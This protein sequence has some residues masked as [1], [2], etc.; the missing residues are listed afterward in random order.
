M[1][2]RPRTTLTTPSVSVVVPCYNY[3]RFLQ[4][5]VRSALD[6]EGVTVEVIIVDD[7]SP[8]GSVVVAH[9]LAAQDDRVRVIAHEENRGH[10]A[11]YNDGLAAVAAKYVVLLSADDLLAPGSLAR[12]TAL[13]ERHP[14]V[15]LVYGYAPTFT[16]DRPQ[17]R[18]APVWG[19]SIWSGERWLRRTCRTGHNRIV[20]PEAVMRTSV[21]A[22]IGAYDPHLPHSADLDLWMRAALVADVGRVNG[23]AQAYY[24]SHGANMHLTDYSGVLTDMKQRA[25]GFDLFFDGPGSSLSN[26]AGLRDAALRSIALEALRTAR[27]AG[28]SG[29][30]DESGARMAEFALECWPPISRTFGAWAYR[31]K[32]I[33]PARRSRAALAARFHSL[34]WQVRSQLSTRFGV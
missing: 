15:G 14:A 18:P 8:D 16:D 12:A 19:W 6:Q 24:R 3:G 26:A 7:A 17:A 21:L 11:T 25:R 31:M 34:R 27:L 13:M 32:D 33:G 20:N 5:A 30:G 2:V 29:S 1:I 4:D 22:K 9:E 10:I 28:T 23:P